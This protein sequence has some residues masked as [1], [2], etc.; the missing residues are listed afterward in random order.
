MYTMPN[1]KAIAY[2]GLNAG[3]CTHH[4]VIFWR[5]LSGFELSTFSFAP[6]TVNFAP[7]TSHQSPVTSSIHH[8]VSENHG[9]STREFFSELERITETDY[10]FQFTMRRSESRA[11]RA[12]E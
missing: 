12:S 10:L 6:S 5:D 1:R 2:P 3:A 9:R 8:T 4:G 7:F 11:W